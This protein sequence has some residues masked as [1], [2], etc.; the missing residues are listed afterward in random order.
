MTTGPHPIRGEADII[1]RFLRPLTNA[2]AGSYGLADDCATLT[3]TPGKD[4]VLKTD[5]IAE[6]VHFFAD[7]PADAI[8]WKALAVNVSDLAAK[9]ATPR[10][11]LMAL[12]FPATPDPLWLAA[13]CSGLADAQAAFGIGLLGG[14][15]DRRPGPLSVSITVIGEV[16]S[17][18][19]VRRATA[20]PGDLLYCSGTI[21][22]AGL[23]FQLRQD[24]AARAVSASERADLIDRW[25]RPRP[26]LALAA[27]LLAHARAAMDVSDGFVKDL[28]RM[29]GA[30]GVGATVSAA[31]V[32]LSAV[33]ARLVAGEASVLTQLLTAGEDYEVLAAVSP[34]TAGAF[35]RDARAAGVSVSRVGRITVGPGVTVTDRAGA[36]MVFARTGWDHF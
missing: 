26:R 33:A 7:D 16:P 27:A 3:P 36:P 2:S 15:T 34:A 5:P 22:D 35:E 4:L 23:G 9:G 1:E 30:A 32:P 6:G 28:E 13:F 31:A 29:C 18:Q 21:G 19:M 25:H 17:G 14:D 20:Q 12:S 8:G 24:P 11:Y 10:G